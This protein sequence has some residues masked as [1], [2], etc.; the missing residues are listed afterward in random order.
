[1]NPV[2]PDTVE[3][4]HRS[5][6]RSHHV[7]YYFTSIQKT[8][9]QT[10][11]AENQARTNC[12]KFQLACSITRGF[13]PVTNYETRPVKILAMSRG[14]LLLPKTA[15]ATLPTSEDEILGNSVK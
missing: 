1:M 6:K 15:S 5:D 12:D 10:S 8:S 4:K 2:N 7:S 13:K 14:A 11:D 3:S 9:H